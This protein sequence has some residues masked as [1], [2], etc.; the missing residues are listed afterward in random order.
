MITVY[1][2]IPYSDPDPKVRQERFELANRAAAYLFKSGLN[3][4]S[5]ISHSHPIALNMDNC[6]NSEFW[7]KVDSFWQK[8]CVRLYVVKAPGW[9]KS[10]GLKREIELARSIKQEIVY[11]NPEDYGY[12]K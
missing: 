11:L 10:T 5:P 7:C 6:N 2:G 9:E 4:M 1:L 8:Q 12:W 3:V